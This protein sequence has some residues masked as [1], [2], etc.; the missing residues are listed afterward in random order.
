MIEWSDQVILKSLLQ[1]NSKA[2]SSVLSLFYGQLSHLYKAT[3]KTIALTIQNFVSKTMSLL[4]NTLS[5]FVIAF[6]P[7]SRHLLISWLQSP[8]TVIFGTQE[9][10]WLLLCILITTSRKVD[11]GWIFT[12]VPARILFFLQPDALREFIHW[13]SWQMQEDE[14]CEGNVTRELGP[15]RHIESSRKESVHLGISFI[16]KLLTLH[17]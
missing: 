17:L 2:S 15:G 8:P 11:Q 6:I 13:S 16:I 7:K 1:H 14:A 10:K 9:N 4:F 3:G 5:G 12:P